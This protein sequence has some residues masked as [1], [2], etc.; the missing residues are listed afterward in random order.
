MFGVPILNSI[1]GL[2][3]NITNNKSQFFKCD[4][5]IVVHLIFIFFY[6]LIIFVGFK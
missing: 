5:N 6:F 2:N 3:N 4:F 1:I